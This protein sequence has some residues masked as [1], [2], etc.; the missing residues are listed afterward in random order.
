MEAK[1][2]DVVYPNSGYQ[3]DMRHTALPNDYLNNKLASF[4]VIHIHMGITQGL[5]Q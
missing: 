3:A 2:C 1:L 4:S 5:T